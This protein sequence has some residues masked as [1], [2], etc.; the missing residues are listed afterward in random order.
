M[1]LIRVTLTKLESVENVTSFGSPTRGQVGGVPSEER[2]QLIRWHA[3]Q[4]R[5]PLQVRS[6]QASKR[7]SMLEYTKLKIIGENTYLVTFLEETTIIF[8]I[9]WKLYSLC[10]EQ[11]PVGG[12]FARPICYATAT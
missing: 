7:V 6:V 5:D 10:S 2:L 1:P 8:N 11:R 3:A 9:V 12:N 4:V